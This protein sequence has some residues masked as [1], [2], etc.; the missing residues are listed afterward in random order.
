LGASGR[1]AIGK[2]SALAC[3]RAHQVFCGQKVICFGKVGFK[4]QGRFS[5]RSSWKV[6]GF[7]SFGDESLNRQRFSK[8]GFFAVENIT[9]L[10]NNRVK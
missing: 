7:T 6:K 10:C 8:S 1:F 9:G 4:A 2:V 5:V 3:S